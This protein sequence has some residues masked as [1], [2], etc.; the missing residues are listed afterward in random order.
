MQTV[1]AAVTDADVEAIERATVDAVAPQSIEEIDGWLLPF[2]SGSIGR[3]KSAVPLHHGIDVSAFEPIS[4]RYAARAQPLVFRLP[5]V[6]SCE[7]FKRHLRT[8]GFRPGKPTLVQIVH[9]KHVLQV[10]SKPLAELNSASDPAWAALFLGEGFDP[11]DGA[12]RVA[13]L[14]RAH[15]TMFASLREGGQTLAAGA[16]AY[17][18]GWASAHGMRTAQ[19]MRGRGLAGRVLA[20]IAQEAIHKGIQRM[21]LQVQEDNAAA[22]ALYRRAGFLTAWRYEYWSNHEH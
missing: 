3:A 7:D 6:P 10:T 17:S 1:A 14:S 15:G 11:V 20:S 19:G 16:G 13:N 21:F 5:H 18:H 9:C 2:D 22:L 8:L 4:A 12:S